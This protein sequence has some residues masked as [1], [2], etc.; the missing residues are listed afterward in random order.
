MTKSIRGS[1]LVLSLLCV[2]PAFAE[3]EIGKTDLSGKNGKN[4]PKY[5]IRN[6]HWGMSSDEVMALEKWKFYGRVGTKIR[7]E[8][9]LKTDVRCILTYTFYNDL[10]VRLEYGMIGDVQLYSFFYKVLWQ[11]YGW[12]KK[13]RSDADAIVQ[14]DTFSKLSGLGKDRLIRKYGRDRLNKMLNTLYANWAIHEN[15]TS[16][17]LTFDSKHLYI[18]Y[19]NKEYSDAKNQLKKDKDRDDAYNA[20]NDL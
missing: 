1:V 14:R 5:A 13:E 8:G 12:P 20:L 11:K 7:F 10:L 19:T 3:D 18:V 9:E 4:A 2:T 17:H 16:L 15:Q 6:T